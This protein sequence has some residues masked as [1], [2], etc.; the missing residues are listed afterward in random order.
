MARQEIGGPCPPD[1][2][3]IP[4]DLVSNEEPASRP[5]PRRRGGWLAGPGPRGNDPLDAVCSIRSD[6][7]LL[8]KPPRPTVEPRR[9]VDIGRILSYLDS[10]GTNRPVEPPSDGGN[11]EN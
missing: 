11:R 10:L 4:G 2:D 8:P 9:T 1:E 3:R 6:L 7:A 5:P